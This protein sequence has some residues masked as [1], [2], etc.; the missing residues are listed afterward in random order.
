[1]Q[2][3][4]VSD[5]DGTITRRDFYQILIDNYRG[6]EGLRLYYQWQS[7]EMTDIDFLNRIFNP[8]N[9]S[10]AA[11][12]EIIASIPLDETAFPFFEWFRRTRGPVYIVSAGCDYYIRQILEF[13]HCSDIPLLA[14]PGYYREGGL[15]MQPDTQSPWYHSIHGI[16]K[17]R[18]VQS[19]SQPGSRVLFAGDSR[20]DREA[21]RSADL[22]FA[23]RDSQL[24][25]ILDTENH[26]YL[27]FSDFD[28][29]CSW[30]EEGR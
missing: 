5:F 22:T 15:Y 28:E 24:A 17:G 9:L 1:M 13:H 8:L 10:E 3:I 29:I 14:N 23:V 18:F 27:A 21:A 11:L 26:P 6:E 20:P 19:L 4:F 30:L 2:E 16:D 7:R 25:G 12:R